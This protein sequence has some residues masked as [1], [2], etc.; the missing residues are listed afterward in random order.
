[1]VNEVERAEL[2]QGDGPRA[3]DVLARRAARGH[4]DPEWQAREVVARQEAFGGQV[5]V[6]VE[7]AE[8][9]GAALVV[10]QQIELPIGLVLQPL[11]LPV[12]VAP[13]LETARLDRLRGAGQERPGRLVHLAPAV[14][15]AV[16]VLREAAQILVNPVVGIPSVRGARQ[17]LRRS[18]RSRA[19][20]SS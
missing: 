11:V 5:A 16:E 2:A 20:R 3:R 14:H 4:E 10:A 7:L 15:G 12:L 1:M 6:G 13:H 9:R 17:F 8:L 18:R 19:E